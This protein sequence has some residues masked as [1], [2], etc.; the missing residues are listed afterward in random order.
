MEKKRLQLETKILQMTSLTCK[1]INIVKVG[2]HP[3]TNMLPKAEIV[4]RG[5][6]ECRILEMHLQL[7]NQQ[8]KTILC[9]CVCVCVCVC[10]CIHTHIYRLWYQNFIITANQK[11]TIDTNKMKI[12]TN[13]KEKSKHYTKNNYQTTRE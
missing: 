11:S 6:Y 10:M 7:R 5:G 9:V 1:D 4:K 12:D 3:H 2:N 8:L 13:K